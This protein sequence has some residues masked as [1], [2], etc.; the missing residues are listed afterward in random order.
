MKVKTILL[1]DDEM[2]ILKSLG[3]DLR[4]EGYEVI[5]AD[6]GVKAL[7]IMGREHPDLLITDLMMEGLD[8]FQVLKY[9][10]KTAPGRPVLILT[11]FGDMRSAID[12]MRLGA[13]DYLLK[14]CELDELIF[15]IDKGLEKQKLLEKLQVQQQELLAEIE[16]R[17]QAEKALQESSEKIKL[18]AYSVAHDLKNPSIAVCGLTRRL[19]K[20]HRLSTDEKSTKLCDQIVKST[21]QIAALVETI[22]SYIATKERLISIEN[23]N[24]GEIIRAVQEEFALQLKKRRISWREPEEVPIIRADRLSMIRVLRNLVDN[25]LKYGGNGLSEIEIGYR[26]SDDFHIF[27]VR[28]DGVGLKEKGDAGIFTHFSRRET[29]RNIE[30][31]GLGL[32]IVKEIAELHHGTAWMEPVTEKGIAFCI[33]L[34]KNL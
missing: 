31:T 33:S 3:K 22:N 24:S 15:R 2:T 5:T 9:S 34:A 29:G 26:A 13:D 16:A 8:G 4:S 6:N 17:K 11:G 32:S 23:I 20:I 10:K 25:A 28:D 1:V 14:P 18:F 19:Q 12:A 7:E 27:S 21:E 30:G